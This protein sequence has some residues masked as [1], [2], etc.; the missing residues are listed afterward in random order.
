MPRTHLLLSL[1]DTASS[2]QIAHLLRRQAPHCEIIDGLDSCQ[3]RPLCRWLQ[4]LPAGSLGEVQSSLDDAI[5]VL[6][7][8]RHAFKSVQLAELRKRLSRLREELSALGQCGKS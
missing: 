3:Q 4:R 1:P 6:E 8:T 5:E 7:G 2:R